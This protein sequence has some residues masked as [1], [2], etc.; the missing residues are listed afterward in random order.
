MKPNEQPLELS[1]ALPKKTNYSEINRV[2]IRQ[3]IKNIRAREQSDGL[4]SQL[5]VQNDKND[6]EHYFKYRHDFD[7]SK[8]VNLRIFIRS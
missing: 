7:I 1:W 3:T 2:W 4:I 5:L 8:M 6:I